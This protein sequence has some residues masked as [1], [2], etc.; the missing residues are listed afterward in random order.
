MKIMGVMI[1]I[2]DRESSTGE[3]TEETSEI[4]IEVIATEIEERETEDIKEDHILVKTIEEGHVEGIQED[5]TIIAD[6]EI[7]KIIAMKNHVV[8]KSIQT[9][10]KNQKHNR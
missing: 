6:Q 3:M 2:I 5:T 1:G 7:M 4:M 9:Q 10:K 8:T